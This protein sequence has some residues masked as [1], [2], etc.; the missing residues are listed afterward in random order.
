MELNLIRASAIVCLWLCAGCNLIR[1]GE[2]AL[3]SGCANGGGGDGGSGGTSQPAQ[4]MPEQIVE[5]EKKVHT[6]MV[7][8]AKAAGT[9]VDPDSLV[10]ATGN[11][12]T[13]VIGVVDKLASVDPAS[14]V[15][16]VDMAFAY[17]D[18]PHDSGGVQPDLPTG[19]YTLRVT[20][21]QKVLDEAIAAN[22][23]V[24]PD[25]ESPDGRPAV[26]GA[27]VELVGADGK[28]VTSLPERLD[29]WPLEVAP[30][31]GKTRPTVEVVTGSRYM[32]FRVIGRRWIT[33]VRIGWKRTE[34]HL[35]E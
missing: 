3:N 27:K 33:C 4:S 11:G 9:A 7:E 34:D 2:D 6:S 17:L 32:E 21:P 16:G 12:A 18:L 23:G 19:Y 35:A 14:L 1:A 29:V 8:E 26:D 5:T 13:V 28:V 20:A 24:A 25:L 31:A 22:G 30:D 15:K 10:D